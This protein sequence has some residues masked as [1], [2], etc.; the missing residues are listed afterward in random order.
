MEVGG[1]LSIIT[2][3]VPPVLGAGPEAEGEGE[4]LG[5]GEAAGDDAAG[6]ETAGAEVLAVV[7]GAVVAGVVGVEL[8]PIKRNA[9]TSRITS[10]KYSFFIFPPYL[11]L[12]ICLALGLV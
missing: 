6:E 8:Q 2:F 4:P 12:N 10:T 3:K 5:L 1:T 11:I 7:A 9:A